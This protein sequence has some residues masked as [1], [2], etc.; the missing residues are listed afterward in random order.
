[1]DRKDIILREQRIIILSND[2]FW[3]GHKDCDKTC[4]PTPV[5]ST[6]THR[7]D[8]IRRMNR[9]LWRKLTLKG[10]TVIITWGCEL[11][12]GAESDAQRG[13]FLDYLLILCRELSRLK[14]LTI[15]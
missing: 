1:M 10:W 5:S 6:L 9:L 15:K 14:L 2:C 7:M 13:N 12:D 3:H 11:I 8:R 4:V